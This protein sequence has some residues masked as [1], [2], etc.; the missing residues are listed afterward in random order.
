MSSHAFWLLLATVDQSPVSV[1]AD[2]ARVESRTASDT[3]V[4]A[5]RNG[6]YYPFLQAWLA[7]GGTVP[8]GQAHRWKQELENRER[9]RSTLQTLNRAAGQSQV[10]YAVIKNASVLDPVPRDVDVLVRD[11]DRDAFLG[12]LGDE[13]LATVSQDAAEYSL[14]GPGLLRVDVY[15]RIHYLGRDFIP[16]AD[17]F[18][19]VRTVE[20]HGIEHPTLSSESSLLMNSVHGLLGHSAV[21]L[22]DFLDLVALRRTI[23]DLTGVR[24]RAER[25]G[26]DAAFDRWV[27][28]IEGLRERIYEEHRVVPFPARHGHRLILDCV[29]S[30]QGQELTRRELR[31][32]NL[33]LLWDDVVYYAEEAGFDVALKR[34]RLAARF[35]NVVGHRLRI[36]RGDSKTTRPVTGTDALGR[37]RTWF[38]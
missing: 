26:W 21:S 35:G 13:G 18:A 25:S 36:L 15:S 28:H 32:L 34:S 10:S 29:G 30:L 5:D 20:T 1:D 27:G 19:S 3:A 11:E 31:I 16:V 2:P 14:L 22:M 7:R 37:G 8:A 17:L 6:L 9:L 38:R 12:A 24:A 33:T 4:L 23:G